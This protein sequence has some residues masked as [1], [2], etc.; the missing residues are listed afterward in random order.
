[1]DD[2]AGFDEEPVYGT[3]KAGEVYKIYLNA[4]RARSVLGWA[5]KVG[6]RECLE[7]T[8]DFLRKSATA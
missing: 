8:V 5:P 4:D 7:A 3:A 6:L 1:M 2:L